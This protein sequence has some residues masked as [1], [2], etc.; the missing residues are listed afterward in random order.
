[1][2][3]VVLVADSGS[4]LARLTAAVGT[5]PGAY[6]VRHSSSA[7]PLDRLLSALA[8]DLV[9]IGDLLEPVNGPARLADVARAAP[10]AKVVL[11]PGDLEPDALG[12]LLRETLAACIV[13]RLPVEGPKPHVPTEAAA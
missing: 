11:A 8:P 13:Q 5:V 6:I 3:G 12:R 10:A 1:M 4:V 2:T 7:R 9:V